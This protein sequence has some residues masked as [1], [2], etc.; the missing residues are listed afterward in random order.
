MPQAKKP[1]QRQLRVAEEIRQLVAQALRT[2]SVLIEGLKPSRLMITQA[3]ISPDLASVLLR[4]RAVPP[5]S[6]TEQ[7]ALMNARKGAFRFKIGKSIRLRIVPD[8]RFAADAD[9][10]KINRVEQLLQAPRVQADV[11]KAV[12]KNDEES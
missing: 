10:E 11:R 9:Q 6:T 12:P 3:E 2:E 1:S 4:V 7:V 5:V 8:V